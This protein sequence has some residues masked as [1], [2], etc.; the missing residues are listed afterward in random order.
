[1]AEDEFAT[2]DAELANLDRRDRRLTPAANAATSTIDDLGKWRRDHDR[3]F[4]VRWIISLYVLSLAAI[5]V[6]LI[7]HGL[8]SNESV[9]ANISDIIKVAIVPVVTLVIGYYFGKEKS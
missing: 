7:I 2:L 6:Y 4:V 3:S 5:I 1:M 8:C 9:Y